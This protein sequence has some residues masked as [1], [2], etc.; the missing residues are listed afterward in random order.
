MSCRSTPF[1]SAVTSYVRK[2]APEFSDSQVQSLYH[3][4]KRELLDDDFRTPTAA[5]F[6]NSIDSFLSQV[7]NS[8][9]VPDSQRE[10][11]IRRLEMARDDSP[12]DARSWSALMELSGVVQTAR[13]QYHSVL[14]NAGHT[15][16]VDASTIHSWITE[17]RGGS[18][19]SRGSYVDY[20][21]YPDQYR[22]DKVPGL[23]QD[24]ATQQ[25]LRKLGYETFLAQ[26]YPVFV[27]GTL[28]QGQG[29]NRVVAG[30]AEKYETGE[31]RGIA[32]YGANRGFPY[33]AEHDSP[34]A[35]TRGEVIWLSSDERGADARQGMDWLEGFNSDDPH[36]SHYERRLHTALCPRTGEQVN[37]WVYLARGSAKSQLQE[38]DR[39]SHGDWVQAR[40]EYRDPSY[41]RSRLLGL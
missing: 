28:R 4:T 40:E 27:Y 19:Q 41:I 36:G 17:A 3:Q 9:Q 18:W 23:P 24:R 37:V 11:L 22:F 13:Q 20:S 35:V 6:A 38:F 15:H 1:S 8:A 31:L 30:G 33:A 29:N 10:S 2:L 7:R 25:A 5:E 14:E 26:P 21:D 12:V 32:I 39:I 34:D 16:N